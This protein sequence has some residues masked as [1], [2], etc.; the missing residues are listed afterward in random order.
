MARGTR[1]NS[2]TIRKGAT[3][4][5]AVSAVAWIDLLGYGAMIAEAGFNPLHEKAAAA[6]KRLRGFH[7]I[8]SANSKRAFP[9]LVMNDGAAAYRDLSVRARSPTHEFVCNAWKL[10][11][12]VRESEAEKE[13]PGARMVIAP[14]FRMRGRRAGID[15]SSGHFASILQRYEKGKITDQQAIR[16]A[17]TISR[18]FDVVPQLQANF[19]FTKAYVA[20]SSGKNAGLAGARCFIDLAFFE[21]PP[22]PWI[23]LGPEIEWTNE[24][25][26]LTA[27]FAP[28]L[29][30][31]IWC[32]PEGGPTEVRDGLQLAQHLAGG[33]DVLKAL[34]DAPR[35]SHRVGETM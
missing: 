8:V 18:S 6:I 12:A 4:P 25:L 26:S 17:T 23:K 13:Y 34:R 1:T 2:P 32:H 15:H 10:F 21:G 24:G 9:T 31:P 19:A 30:L 29:D 14:G 3:F 27:K 11:C 22:P 20:E 16:E 35:R 7:A 28:I 5:F 33:F